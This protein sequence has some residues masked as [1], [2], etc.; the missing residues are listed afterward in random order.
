MSE[1]VVGLRLRTD[2]LEKFRAIAGL[3][4]EKLLAERMSVHESTVNK[5]LGGRQTPSA[6]FIGALVKA[7][8]GLTFDDLWEIVADDVETSDVHETAEP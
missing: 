2:Q 5:V 3:T 8:N 1:R 6:R 4:T 7:F